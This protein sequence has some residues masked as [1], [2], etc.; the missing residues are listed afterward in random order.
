M[1]NISTYSVDTI[2]NT[3]KTDDFVERS[4]GTKAFNAG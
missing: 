1:K 3:E 4:E 2:E